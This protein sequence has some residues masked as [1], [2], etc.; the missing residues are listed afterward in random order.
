MKI[1][2]LAIQDRNEKDKY[3]KNSLRVVACGEGCVCVCVCVC[4]CV[5]SQARLTQGCR[6]W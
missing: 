5:V 4:A 2:V 1:V 3:V 6:A